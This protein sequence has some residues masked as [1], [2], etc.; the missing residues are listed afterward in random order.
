MNKKPSKSVYLHYA[1]FNEVKQYSQGQSKNK[2]NSCVQVMIW[3]VP[4][5]SQIVSGVMSD[6]SRNVHENPFIIR[7]SVMFS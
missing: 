1:Y 3:N 2:N 5:M 6:L 4:K 7:F